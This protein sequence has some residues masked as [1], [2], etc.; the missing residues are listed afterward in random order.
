MK[1]TIL[2]CV[3][4]IALSGSAWAQDKAQEPAATATQA[5]AMDMTKMGPGA[6]KPTN[7]KQTKKE[8][9]EFFKQQEELAKKGD[10]EAMMATHDF[11]LYMAT[12]DLKGVPEAREFSREEYVAM[13]KPFY[14]NMPKD[15]KVTHKPTIT[16]LSDS[17]VSVTD[18]FTMTVGK[19]KVT[20]RNAALLVKRDG[21]WKWKTMIEAGWGGMPAE[22]KK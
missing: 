12:D 16:V 10:M 7:E 5:P 18:D 19:Q 14:E 3:T 21:Q 2:V 15:M 8:V 11:P 13:M 22:G 4:A 20:G 9:Q 6:R 17:L 1:R